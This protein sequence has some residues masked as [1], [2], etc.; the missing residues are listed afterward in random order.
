VPS[1]AASGNIATINTACTAWQQAGNINQLARAASALQLSWA[2]NVPKIP[3]LTTHNTWVA[4]KKV[5]GYTPLQTM[6]YPL[7]N[8]VWINS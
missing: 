3:I 8:D 4:Q 2:R 6:L 1:A 7:Y 5:M